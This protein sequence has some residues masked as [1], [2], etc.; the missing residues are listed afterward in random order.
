MMSAVIFIDI[1]ASSLRHDSY[2]VEVAWSNRAGGEP[3]VYLINPY[4]VPSWTD[5]SPG[6]QAIHRI[7]REKLRMEGADPVTVAQA[8]AADLSGMTVYCDAPDFDR[9]W[10]DKLFSAVGRERP[11]KLQHSALVW[12]RMVDEISDKLGPNRMYAAKRRED[13]IDA[14]KLRGR[15]AAGGQHRAALDVRYLEGTRAALAHA[16]D[17]VLRHASD[18]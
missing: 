16:I 6:A 14:A 11:F 12:H 1:E 3:V 9:M 5:W 17:E 2:P 7:S 10:L 4:C 18:E 15:I 8:L 13:M